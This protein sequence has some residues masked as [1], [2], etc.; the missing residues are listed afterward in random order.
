MKK[1]GNQGEIDTQILLI[2]WL[3]TDRFSNATKLDEIFINVRK[4]IGD[5]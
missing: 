3:E 4:K 2:G 1:I 5:I